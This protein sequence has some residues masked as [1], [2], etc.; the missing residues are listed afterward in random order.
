M[1]ISFRWKKMFLFGEQQDQWNG[2]PSR[3]NR[4]QPM[5]NEQDGD[6]ESG[7]HTATAGVQKRQT[8]IEWSHR[9]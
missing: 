4:S 5:N 9:R 6:R 7:S 1:R 3:S 8:D 2:H